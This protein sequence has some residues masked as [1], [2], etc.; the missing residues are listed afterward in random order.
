[1]G[2][3]STKA[4]E[5]SVDYDF[6]SRIHDT[7]IGEKGNKDRKEFD[8]QQAIKLEGK[9]KQ[10]QDNVE[11]FADAANKDYADRLQQSM[12]KMRSLHGYDFTEEDFKESI[13]KNLENWD[14]FSQGMEPEK[15]E[16]FEALSIL[17]LNA[18][19]DELKRIQESLEAISSEKLQQT[20]Q[21]ANEINVTRENKSGLVERKVVASEADAVIAEMEN[22]K[23]SFESLSKAPSTGKSDIF[24]SF[25]NTSSVTQDIE[26]PKTP[27]SNNIFDRIV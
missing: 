14:E 27:V 2:N 13:R 10:E 25:A 1:M 6:F 3:N 4:P 5:Q 16:K 23:G 9:K 12:E 11:H 22:N 18:T 19:G 20:E 17:A 8:D 21:Q 26:I 24:N 15:A 7:P